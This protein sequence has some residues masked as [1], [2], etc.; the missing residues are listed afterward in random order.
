MRIFKTL[1]IASSF[2]LIIVSGVLAQDD[3]A[4]PG[5]YT[6]TA[7]VEKT[8][9]E[10]A[11][12]FITPTTYIFST[13]SGVSLEDMSSGTTDLLGPGGDNNNSALTQMGFLYRYDDVFYTSFGVN[14]NGFLKIGGASISASNINT[15]N[16]TPN[17][18][19]I[20]PYWDDLCIGNTGKVHYK[21]VGSPG[22]Q[23]L[24][25]EWKNM[26][27][28]KG[29]SCDGT[30]S[31]TFQ[32][33]LFERSGLIQFVYGDGM[34]TAATP[35][36]G[37]SIGIQSGAASNFASVT[38]ADNS[39]SYT[40]ANNVQITAIQ[41]GTSYIFTPNQPPAPSGLSA[42][43]VTQTSVTINWTDNAFSETAYLVR[44]TTDGINYFFVGNTLPANSTSFT[45]NG[46]QPGVAYTYVVNALTEGAFSADASILLAT[47]PPRNISSTGSGGPWS[48][49]STWV[50]GAVPDTNDNVTIVSGA[51]VTIDIG[52]AVA[53]DV[54]IGTGGG[55]PST[56]QFG[57]TGAFALQV[58]RNVT[59]GA[60]DFFKTGSGNGN[61]HQLSV[62]GNI[63]NNGTLDFSTNNNQAGA[64]ILF[65]GPNSTTFGGGGPVTD[66]RTITLYKENSS[67]SIVELTA[68]NF[69]V[70]GS[71]TDGPGSAYLFLYIGTFKI[72]GTFTGN[73][74]T[75][76]SAA[77]QIVQH[78]GIWLNNPNYTVTGQSANVGFFGLFRLTA[79]SYN[80]G[81]GTGHMAFYRTDSTVI[82]EGGSL[83]ITGGLQG[84]GFST[85]R[86]TGGTITTCTWGLSAAGTACFDFGTAN[87][88]QS[89]VMTGGDM[90]VQNPPG[91]G[92][93]YLNRTP[94]TQ[95]G[96]TVLHF[97]NA[98]TAGAGVFGATGYIP[99]I[100]IDTTGGNHRFL[101]TSG[102]S[103]N[104]ENYVGNII[105]DAGGTVEFG[106]D[107]LNIR[108]ERFINNGVFKSTSSLG[109]V[110]IAANQADFEYTGSGTM[111]GYIWNL[112][113]NRNL[114][115]GTNVGN[116]RVRNIEMLPG[117]IVNAS[118]LTIGNNDPQENKITFSSSAG[119][120]D[121]A[122]TF[123]I[124]PGWQTIEYYGAR[125]TGPEINPARTLN[126]LKFDNPGVLT[127]AGGDITIT[128]GFGVPQGEIFT[129]P[130]KLILTADVLKW[131]GLVSSPSA[132]VNTGYVNGTI[133]FRIAQ[134][135]PY[136]FPMGHN[137][138]SPV[139]V[140]VTALGANPSWLTVSNFN[141]NLPGLL[142]TNSVSRYWRL[143]EE[144]DITATLSF[145]YADSDVHGD[146]NAYTL[147]RSTG[148][149]PAVVPSSTINTGTNT[150][151]G[152][153]GTTSF[154][155]DWGIGTQLNGPVSISGTVKTSG[156]QPIRNAQVIISGG[157]LPAPVTFITG[158]FGTYSFEGLEAGQTY[159]INVSVKRYRFPAG[160]QQVTPSGNVTGI[161]FIANPQE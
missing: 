9:G 23:R 131:N 13:Q 59:I 50:G 126:I 115:F 95:M 133:K 145:S 48:S 85:F 113:V 151:T 68:A 12:E 125:T 141:T 94:G 21:L 18:P 25:I 81:T 31:G 110:S 33:W 153:S 66:V 57:E 148:G 152:P 75:F 46:L 87:G 26:K 28:T 60:N 97:G 16:S 80:V 143:T 140:Q 156:G 103:S 146:E 47:V 99:N 100:H 27:I 67:S 96:A 65:F 70:Q 51:T 64:G 42:T 44:R 71:T 82:I 38:T 128:N 8:A 37:Y 147:W 102:G 22:S 137:G 69:T 161:D 112:K 116:V 107:P 6:R 45:E 36:G 62:G 7:D 3:T 41:S 83:N 1:A 56:L 5:G 134:V 117:S 78:A 92:G 77:Y 105:L 93:I 157:N 32:V 43:N 144:G 121:S 108:G 122:P 76:A 119:T 106:S 155:G 139:K 24:V 124:G 159:N 130:H 61:Q 40:V 111:T 154:D 35:N 14:A 4:A 17:A 20:M 135:A 74:R 109:R 129:G 127:I 73:H 91:V 86:I 118:K 34:V 53:G 142:P 138:Y 10:P 101:F 11:G 15:I 2:L 54:T 120:F 49:S 90:V 136:V 19:K 72:S 63:T 104:D 58:T 98:L 123:E 114:V 52:N 160:G 150:V 149:T 29:N 39:V 55:S 89:I 79:G 84:G 132:I 30:G 88:G 158:T